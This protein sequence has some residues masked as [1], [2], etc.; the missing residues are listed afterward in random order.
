MSLDFIQLG[1][2]NISESH[3]QGK[4]NNTKLHVQLVG[5]ANVTIHMNSDIKSDWIQNPAKDDDFVQNPSV[6]LDLGG[7]VTSCFT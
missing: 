1:T 7:K 4:I 2:E 6:Y 3:T 5:T